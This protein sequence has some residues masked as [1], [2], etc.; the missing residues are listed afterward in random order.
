MGRIGPKISSR[1]TAI[2]SSACNTSAGSILRDPAAGDSFAGLISTTVAPRE[3][4]SSSSE[5]RRARC[6]SLT[7]AV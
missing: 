3:R 1:I 5:A 6:R 4:A 7:I 2:E